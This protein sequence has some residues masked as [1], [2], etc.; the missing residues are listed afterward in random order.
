MKFVDKLHF[1]NICLCQH[2]SMV[3]FIAFSLCRI[4]ENIL[5]LSKNVTGVLRSMSPFLQDVMLLK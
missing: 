3:I 2:A 5:S 1:L 4:K